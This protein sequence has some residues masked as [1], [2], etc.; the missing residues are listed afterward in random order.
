MTKPAAATIITSS[1][2]AMPAPQNEA[3][4][5]RKVMRWPL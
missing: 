4:R 5:L 2:V 1:V 3:A